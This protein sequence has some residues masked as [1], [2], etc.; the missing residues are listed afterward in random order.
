MNPFASSLPPTSIEHLISLRH[1]LRIVVGSDA[2]QE[3]IDTLRKIDSSA[4]IPV[5][6]EYLVSACGNYTYDV[7]VDAKIHVV[8]ETTFG[9]RIFDVTMWVFG[10]HGRTILVNGQEFERNDIFIDIVMPFL[11]NEEADIVQRF[12]ND[13]R[14]WS[15]E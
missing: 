6:S 4:L 13:D 5:S 15:R 7:M 2:L 1:E 11:P 3:H 10:E 9:R 14:M 12:I 8:F